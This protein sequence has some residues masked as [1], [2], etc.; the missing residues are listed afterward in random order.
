[1]STVLPEIT[2]IFKSLNSNA[3]YS[4]S[5]LYK[6]LSK[7]ANRIRLIDISSKAEAKNWIRIIR[8]NIIINMGMKIK[9]LGVNFRWIVT[10][11]CYIKNLDMSRVRNK[12]CRNNKE[13]KRSNIWS[14]AW[15]PE[16]RNKSNNLYN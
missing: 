7:L 15:W 5:V 12:F 2:M 14:K 6:F 11:L 13:N 9:K 3:N 4:G 16:V 10:D 1:M 8:A